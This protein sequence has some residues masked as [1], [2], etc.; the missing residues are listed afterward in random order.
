MFEREGGESDKCTKLE[1]G[2]RFIVERC[3]VDKSLS[4]TLP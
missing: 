4:I 2:P 1:M 3:D